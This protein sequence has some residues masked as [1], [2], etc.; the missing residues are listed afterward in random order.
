MQYMNA[1]DWVM[2]GVTTSEGVIVY[3]SNE[4]TQAELRERADVEIQMFGHG[5]V[6]TLQHYEVSAEMRSLV[7]ATGVDYAEALRKIM[8][9]W[10][11]ASRQRPTLNEG[12][13][14][15]PQGE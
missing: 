10:T 12:V 2:L 4:L 11:P 14:A 15:L 6:D 13:R 8:T 9:M 7:W 5:I 1:P 3:A